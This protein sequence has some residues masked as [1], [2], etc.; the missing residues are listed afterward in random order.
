LR[1]MRVA[2]AG[3]GGVGGGHLLTLAR[4]GVGVFHIADPDR[5][6]VANLNRQAGAALHTLGRPKVEVLAEM[7]RGINPE[8]EILPFPKGVSGENLERFLAG[9]DLFID[10]LDFF[11]L[12]I[13]ARLFA[14]CHAQGI[15]AIT[16]APLGMGSAYLVFPRGGMSF[17]AY[18]RLAGESPARQQIK[19]ALGLSP[20]GLHRAYLVDPS[21]VDFAAGRGPSTIMACELCAGVA[22]V[23]ALKLLLGRGAIRGAPHYHQYDPYRERW[24]RGWLPGGNRNPIQRLRLRLAYRLVERLDRSARP[25]EPPLPAG[26]TELERILDLA[27]WAPSGDNI[28]PWRFEPVGEAQVI[29]HAWDQAEQDVYDYQGAPSLLSIGALLETLRIAASGFGRGCRWRYETTQPHRHRL[30]V[31]LPHEA[32]VRAD[33]LLPFV[34]LRSVDRRRYRTTPLDAQQRWMLEQA[35]G[36]EC[37]ITWYES[38]AERWRLARLHARATHIR[39]TIPEAYTIHRRILDW[40]SRFS[41]HGIPAAAVGVDPLTQRIMQWVMQEWRRVAWMNRYLGGTLLTRWQLDLWPGLRCGA[42]FALHPAQLLPERGEAR[43]V[44]LLQAGQAVQRLWLTATRLG[45]VMQPALATLCFA[46]YGR[47]G[48]PFSTNRRAAREAARLAAA[49][50]RVMGEGADPPIFLGRIGY[51]VLHATQSRSLRRPL[52]E[53]LVTG[54]RS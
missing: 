50:S 41:R 7:A 51:P 42:Q 31:D 14:R 34:P 26:A 45:L 33:P 37:R 18:F 20:R 1:G 35:A 9:V 40:N 13:R 53:L 10:G 5:F 12:D 21:R 29:I 27:R 11:V 8:A 32:E 36:P 24:V 48:E 2:I 54:Q 46:H 17:E 6:E 3:V 28:Q 30:V 19:F 16:A 52:E 39:M 4:L 25:S 38:R 22:G 49:L 44:A 43:T 23:E 47:Y 15:P